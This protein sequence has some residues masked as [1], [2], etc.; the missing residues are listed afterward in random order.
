MI[1][2]AGWVGQMVILTK[3]FA[4]MFLFRIE[5]KKNLVSF[6]FVLLPFPSLVVLF[7]VP[8]CLDLSRWRAMGLGSGI[9][10]RGGGRVRSDRARTASTRSATDRHRSATDRCRRF[11]GPAVVSSPTCKE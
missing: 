8:R 2:T 10:S 7:L 11:Q 5:R 3:M 6:C 4:T 9:H 1:S